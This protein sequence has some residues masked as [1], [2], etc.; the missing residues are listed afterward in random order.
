MSEDIGFTW[1][2]TFLQILQGSLKE[3]P[4]RWIVEGKAYGISKFAVR[5]KVTPGN[6]EFDQHPV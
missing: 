4:F 2:Q 3:R 1:R 5:K 6:K